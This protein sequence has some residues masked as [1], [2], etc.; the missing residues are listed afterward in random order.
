[1][2]IRDMALYMSHILKGINWC[3]ML[4]CNFCT[5]TAILVPLFKL[6]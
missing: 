2:T 6:F 4:I 5:V 1:M 3:V